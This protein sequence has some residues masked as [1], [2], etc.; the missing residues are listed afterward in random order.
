MPLLG[1]KENCH[2]LIILSTFV[3]LLWTLA[4]TTLVPVIC[5]SHV[6]IIGERNF[7]ML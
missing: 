5:Y 2:N 1:T 4:P 6:S 3:E 7:I